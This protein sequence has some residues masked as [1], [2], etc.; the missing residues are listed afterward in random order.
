MLIHMD[1]KGPKLVFHFSIAKLFTFLPVSVWAKWVQF[2]GEV[3]T[4][5]TMKV[6][7]PDPGTPT[8]IMCSV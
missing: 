1:N 3:I 6:K 5:L 4:D 2:C 8:V 7:L